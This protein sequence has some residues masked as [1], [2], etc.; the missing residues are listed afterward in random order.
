[1]C[2]SCHGAYFVCV[3]G[4]GAARARREKLAQHRERSHALKGIL[5]EVK[6]KYLR[7]RI[8][9]LHSAVFIDDARF[10]LGLVLQRKR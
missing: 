10:S 2:F 9:R 6:T 8:A 7:D 5:P 1:M 4:G 3:L